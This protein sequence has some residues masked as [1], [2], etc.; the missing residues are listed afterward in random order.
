MMTAEIMTFGSGWLMHT[1]MLIQ[2][3]QWM[4]LRI[5][6]TGDSSMDFGEHRFARTACLGTAS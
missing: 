4:P 2:G 1:D 5:K 6:L 3:V